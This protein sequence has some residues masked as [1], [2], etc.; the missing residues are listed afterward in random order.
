MQVDLGQKQDIQNIRIIWEKTN[1]AYQYKIE[2]S[3]D[4]KQWKLL[5]DQSKNK[6][7]RQITP[8][9]VNAKNT[10]YFKV[11]FLG[12]KPA[13]WGSLWEFEAYEGNLPDLPRKVVKASQKSANATPKTNDPRVTAPEGFNLTVFAK[14][15]LVNYPVCLTA[16][17][18]G[19]LFVGID[20]QGSLGK[21]KGRGRVVRCL[22]TN[23]DGKADQVNT[24]AKMDHPRGLIYDNG[25]L[26]V[27]HPPYLTLYEDTNNDGVADKED[28]LISGISTDYV[29]KRGADHTTNGIRMGIDGWIYIAVGDFG[30]YKAIGKDGRKLSRR[31]GGIVR[32]RPDGTEMEIYNW[33]QRNILDA[34]IDPY[35]NIFTRDNTNDGGGWDIRFSHIIQTSEYG[36]PSWYKNFSDEIMPALADYGGGS[37][38][39]GM[40]Y[41]DTRWPKP[42][43]HAVYTLSLIH[44]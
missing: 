38:C 33:G 32:V 14:P 28:Q 23:G 36:Y 24:F 13:C 8:H 17:S 42:F 35:L 27:L 37:G 44:I 20:E 15:P 30:F 31:G 22:D 43:S 29:S 7:V 5:V 18:T 39:G 12:S 1:S 21:Q 3:I 34:C 10:R 4:K 41:H 25:Q 11:T 16:A 19:E 6:D 26:W 9:K 40:F 2:G